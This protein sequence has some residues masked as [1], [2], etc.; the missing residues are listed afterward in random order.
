MMKK[1]ILHSEKKGK[2]KLNKTK[3]NVMN[4]KQYYNTY[5]SKKKQQ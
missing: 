4:K 5:Q 1:I 3:R 2:N